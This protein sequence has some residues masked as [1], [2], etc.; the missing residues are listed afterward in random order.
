MSA[1]TDVTRAVVERAG[2]GPGGAGKAV[3]RCSP[4]WYKKFLGDTRTFIKMLS[5]CMLEKK[6]AHQD[7]SR[8]CLGG[9][10]VSS[11]F[12][13]SNGIKPGMTIWQR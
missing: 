8:Y 7:D 2:S 5:E 3:G 6:I 1:C 12:K 13:V 11:S 9:R 10:E 4:L